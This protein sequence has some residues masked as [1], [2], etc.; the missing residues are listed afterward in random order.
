MK[1]KQAKK[2]VMKGVFEMTAKRILEI[3]EDEQRT[4]EENCERFSTLWM[5]ATT[6]HDME[7]AD[8]MNEYANAWE[9]RVDAIVGL[10]LRIENAKRCEKHNKP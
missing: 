10:K 1:P 3:I 2:Q 7:K 9:H 4:A 5:E 8:K 6:A